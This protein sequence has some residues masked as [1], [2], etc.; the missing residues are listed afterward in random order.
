MSYSRPQITTRIIPRQSELSVR[1]GLTVLVGRP[2]TGIIEYANSLV[3]H[4]QC[5]NI[6]IL[7]TAYCDKHVQRD[8]IIQRAVDLAAKG[9]SVVLE[10]IGTATIDATLRCFYEAGISSFHLQSTLGTIVTFQRENGRIVTEV[11][12]VEVN[13]LGHFR[14]NRPFVGC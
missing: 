12:R 10:W 7:R 11:H 6:Q 8:V 13:R 3:K 14:A 1:T 5:E 2:D 9:E 4:P